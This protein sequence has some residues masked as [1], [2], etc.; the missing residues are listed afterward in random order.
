MAWGYQDITLA[1]G[2]DAGGKWETWQ[3]GDFALCPRHGDTH[4]VKMGRVYETS[5][6][7]DAKLGVKDE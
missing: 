2:C 3:V 6:S 1:C 5:G 4:V 7:R